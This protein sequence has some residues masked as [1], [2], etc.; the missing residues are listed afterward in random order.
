MTI[1]AAPCMARQQSGLIELG[2]LY[3]ALEDWELRVY[4]QCWG[5]VKQFWR[6]PQFIRVTDDDNA[7][8]FVGLNQPIPG[9]PPTV[10][11]DPQT[12]M[13]K[14]Q[15]GVLGYKN[16][17]AEM[18][19]D[20]EVDAQPDVG[21]IQQEAFNE[22]MHLVG[23][24]PIYQQQVPL[25]TLIQLSPIPHKRSVLDVIKQGEQAQQEAAARQQETAQQAEAAKI[26]ETQARTGLH[27]ATGFAKTL[28][29]LTYAHATHADH[30][31]AGLEKGI[32]T[33]SQAQA[34]AQAQQ[35]ETNMQTSDQAA[36]ASQA[37]ADQSQDQDPAASGQ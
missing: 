10:G 9:G 30:V 16:L 1:P 32:D 26:A 13:P 6:A 19:V 20:I 36:A 35:H 27:Q 17:V 4:R 14:L 12:G 22:L 11:Q 23:T 7:P 15:P 33:A 5:R 8:K 34:Q 29:S 28:D 37:Q 31:A 25:T 18:D 21:T 3:G 2:N 24:S